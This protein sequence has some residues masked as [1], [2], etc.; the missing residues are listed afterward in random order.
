MPR[1]NPQTRIAVLGAGT[2]GAAVVAGLDAIDG[3]HVLPV[4]VRDPARERPFARH[5][6]RVTTD[7]T[8]ATRGADLLVE[9]LGGI[10]P[11]AS[12]MLQALRAGKR[13]VTANKAALAERWDDFRPFLD[14]GML[15]I[16]AAVMAGTPVIGPLAGPLRGSRPLRLQAVLNGTCNVILSKME[17]GVAFEAALAGAQADGLAEEDPTLDVEGIDTA[18]KLALLARFVFDPAMRWEAVASRTRGVRE[19]SL[20]MVRRAAEEGNR[21]RLVASIQ[22]GPDGWQ[23]EVRPRALPLD[24]PLARLEGSRNGMLFQGDPIGEVFIEG[25]GAGAGETASGVLGDVL[26]ALRGVPAPAPVQ[27]AAPLP[28]LGSPEAVPARP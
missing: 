4:L 9:L 5:R 16:E 3:V 15:Y 23:A 19:V 1:M 12:H 6:E 8:E 24:A 18:H 2:V 26:A 25:P 17:Q 7:P 13:V 11:A 22:A 14:E 28:E 27:V 10:E 20:A 21:I